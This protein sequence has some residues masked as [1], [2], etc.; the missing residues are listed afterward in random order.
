MNA[1]EFN[2][3]NQMEVRAMKRPVLKAACMLLLL[4]AAFFTVV[5][6]ARK[7]KEIKLTVWINGADSVIGPTEQQKPQEEWYISQAF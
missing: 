6:C 4:T 7:P 5:S 3:T 1:E 2:F